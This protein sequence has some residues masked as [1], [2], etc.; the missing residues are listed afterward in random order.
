MSVCAGG[1]GLASAERP[2]PSEPEQTEKR[3]P[4]LDLPAEERKELSRVR[5]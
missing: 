3:D 4:L 5:P 1:A 2:Q